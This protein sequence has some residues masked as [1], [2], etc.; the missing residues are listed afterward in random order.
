MIKKRVKVLVYLFIVIDGGLYILFDFECID[1]LLKLLG[2]KSAISI[3]LRWIIIV[4]AIT[5]EIFI[6]RF[7][8]DQRKHE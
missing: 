3:I 1:A 6:N 8:E 2:V 5:L 4:L 7:D